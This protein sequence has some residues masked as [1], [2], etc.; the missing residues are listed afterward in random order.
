MCRFKVDE[1]YL[2][3]LN[4]NRRGKGYYELSPVGGA[5]E[6]DHLSR[7]DPFEARPENPASRDLRL[8]MELDRLDAFRQWFYKR[9]GRET[10]PFREIYEE[11]VEE[12]GILAALRRED[13][14]MD[15]LH[16]VEDRKPTMRLGLTGVFTHYFFE[17]FEVKARSP[18]IQLRLKN[19]PR[20]CGVALV[21]EETA[22]Q[23]NPLTMR[24]DGQERQVALNTQ[25]LFY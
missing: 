12:T 14:R 7:L 9:Q 6:V 22:R 11:L 24:I 8:R 5:I 1:R 21:D 3:V 16:I 18:D 4:R 10:D 20:D 15:F 19:P 2:L 23:G 25:Y 17:V 13:L